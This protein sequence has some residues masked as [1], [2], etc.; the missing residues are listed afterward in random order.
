MC[1]SIFNPDARVLLDGF[2][3]VILVLS[4]SSVEPDNNEMV[5][6]QTINIKRLLASG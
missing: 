6:N 2:D 4:G 1:N 5:A 3:L